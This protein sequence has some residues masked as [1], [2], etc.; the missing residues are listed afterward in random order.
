MVSTLKHWHTAFHS[1]SID[2][3]CVTASPSFRHYFVDFMYY[4]F[5]KFLSCLSVACTPTGMF[6]WV[7]LTGQVSVP[8]ILDEVC[9]AALVCS[10]PMQCSV[11]SSVLHPLCRRHLIW[12]GTGALVLWVLPC[13]RCS[14]VSPRWLFSAQWFSSHFWKRTV[15]ALPPPDLVIAGHPSLSSCYLKPAPPAPRDHPALES[16][17]YIFMENTSYLMN[18]LDLAF[19]ESQS[20]AFSIYIH[21]AF[22]IDWDFHGM[23]WG[24]GD[25][26]LTLTSWSFYVSVFFLIK[27]Q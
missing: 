22:T 11:S 21:L 7:S 27:W 23:W 25:F 5:L 13:D 12:S 24:R 16:S 26:Y 17:L 14:G 18:R 19:T 20:G 10:C 3:I 2:C 9:S 1:N 8:M 15:G 6:C 4:V